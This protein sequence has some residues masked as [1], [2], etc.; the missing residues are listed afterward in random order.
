MTL[1]E[2]KKEEKADREFQKK[3]KVRSK[4]Q[5]L[6]PLNSPLT[7]QGGCC[8]E[9][10][11]APG[12]GGAQQSAPWRLPQDRSTPQRCVSEQCA[13]P[14]EEAVGAQPAFLCSCFSSKGTSPS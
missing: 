5:S 4:E 7:V 10:L 14:M 9:E 6:F 13:V 8:A 12:A 2:C 11:C 1:K 3:F